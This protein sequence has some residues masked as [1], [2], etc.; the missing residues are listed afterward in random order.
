[1]RI[2]MGKEGHTSSSLS[3]NGGAMLGSL[4]L[5]NG[6][7][8]PLEAATKYYV[9]TVFSTLNANNIVNGII[10]VSSLP[11]FTGDISNIQGSNSFSLSSL[12]VTPG[13]YPKVIVDAKGR[14]TGNDV[15][16]S[17]DVPGFSWLKVSNKPVTL[18]DYGI[19]NVLSTN[20]G[21][22][23]GYLSVSNPT[24]AMSAA[25]KQYVN[26]ALS[27][28]S[29][30]VG[31]IIRK[32]YSNTPLG[33]LRCNGG[34]VSKSLYPDLYALIGNNFEVN[35]TKG[36][37]RPWEQQYEFNTYQSENIINW[38]VS[39][40]NLPYACLYHKCVV[41]RNRVY[42]I[43]GG[44]STSRFTTVYTAQLLSEGDIGTWSAV[45]SLPGEFANFSAIV[46]KNRLY[47]LAGGTYANSATTTV[48]TTIINT[49]GTLGTWMSAA[50]LPIT[51][52]NASVVV[53]KNRV[54][55]LG[56]HNGTNSINT[57][58]Y[59]NINTDGT[60]GT[61]TLYTSVIPAQLSDTA[62]AIVKNRLYILGGNTNS[63]LSNSIFSC[64]INN[65]G[66]LGTWVT[67]GILPLSL[68]AASCVVTKNCVYMIGGAYATNTYTANTYKANIN[69]DGS[70]SSW[71]RMDDLHFITGYSSAIIVKNKIYIMGGYLNNAVSSRVMT[72]QFYNISQDYAEYYA[73]SN[74]VNYMMPGSG[75]PWQQ[76]YQT[77]SSQTTAI[78]GWTAESA[79]PTAVGNSQA[80]VTKNRVYLLGGTSTGSTIVY[81]ASINTDGTLSAWA[82]DA[83][84]PISISSEQ[85]VVTKNYVYL[86]G[87][88]SD[89]AYV[90][91]VYR[92]PINTDGTI[93]TWVIDTYLPDVL[94]LS[95]AIVT[96]NRVY[97]LGGNTI[98]GYVST[99][100]TAPINTD[101]TL[102]TWT[103]TN[104]LPAAI[105]ASS[106][107]I[108]N[109]R[110]YLIGGW[111]GTPLN[112]VYTATINSDGYIGPWVTATP[113]PTALGYTSTFVS[114]GKIY[115]IGGYNG[116]TTSSTVY[117]ADIAA[118]GTISSWVVSTSLSTGFSHSSLI[119]T[120]S[121]VFLI[122][123]YDSTFS[124][125][126]F[127]AN[128]TGG[129]NDYTAYY[130]GSI[131]PATRI[132]DSAF[133]AMPDFTNKEK[134]GSYLFMKF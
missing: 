7:S 113:L 130:D 26:S 51:I 3:A 40:Q 68:S 119:V 15:L 98:S 67:S 120:N 89:T 118:D 19:A 115:V 46:V 28:N 24:Q 101:G 45:N 35:T 47:V 93:G 75:K 61:W 84:L 73:D 129:L 25:N 114:G 83:P 16:A 70:L 31:D 123:G 71:E 10:P 50:S 76:Q 55:I 39:A 17:H 77:N 13:S 43:G 59:A 22:V 53:I 125:A 81:T 106:V 21:I 108:T 121:K 111:N 133:F 103:I 116:T 117:T 96:K 79:L 131:I 134:N 80:F 128:L 124:S 34:L 74:T 110:I 44:N 100:Y 95:Q 86:L 11:I 132:N 48:Y 99:V 112:T 64:P 9:D 90:S 91:T 49:D 2:N 94:G 107:A 23:N 92:A 63:V 127:S 20:G 4:I 97:L 42:L 37:G 69:L 8:Q 82:T 62:I 52:S 1:M 88:Y 105:S 54:Y 12:G 104:S 33:F 18:S 72:A 66:S 56:G 85:V 38:T 122:G 30:V 102:G 32:P 78:S 126:V 5:A 58:Y 29:T 41:T 36:S 14:V 109:N 57:I 60:L 65:D 6:P 87:G 27:G